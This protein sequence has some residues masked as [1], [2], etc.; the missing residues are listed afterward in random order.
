MLITVRLPTSWR[1]RK[2]IFHMVGL[3]H[4]LV[5]HLACSD[6]TEPQSHHHIGL[7]FSTRR[8]RNQ[9][10]NERLNVFSLI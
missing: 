3:V 7:A 4:T 1:D 9:L 5:E 10:L 2:G 8:P 6:L